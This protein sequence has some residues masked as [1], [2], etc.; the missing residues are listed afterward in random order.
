MQRNKFVYRPMQPRKTTYRWM[1]TDGSLAIKYRVTWQAEISQ[2]TPKWLHNH[3][4]AK[5]LAL[6]WP[7]LLFQVSY[8]KR[9]VFRYLSTISVK[10]YRKNSCGFVTFCFGNVA[11]LWQKPKID[12]FV[13]YLTMT[14]QL[15]KITHCTHFL[16]ANVYIDRKSM[17]RANK[18]PI[19]V[20]TF[21]SSCSSSRW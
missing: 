1:G 14:R 11:L 8:F 10:L 13:S 21:S 19:F 20:K 16:V 3:S 5:M 17:A 9:I 12:Y 4:L 2:P 6:S 18:A 7:L 15:V